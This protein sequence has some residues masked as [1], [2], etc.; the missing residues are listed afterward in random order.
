MQ[1]F[2]IQKV[3]KLAQDRPIII[4]GLILFL[5]IVFYLGLFLRPKIKEIFHLL[6]EVSRLKTAI[7][8][9]E[10]EWASIDSLKKQVLQLNEKIDYYEKR[11]PSEKEIPAVLK[12]LSEAA[13]KMNVKIIEIRPIE[14][15]KNKSV[16]TSLYYKV[17]IFLKAECG[18]HQLGRFLSR[19][20]MADRFMKISDIEIA[21]NPRKTN[22]HNVQL[23]VVTYG[24]QRS[25]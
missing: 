9:T 15:K 2:T 7:V 16:P 12:Y 22:T 23:T 3:K 5:I 21:A 4:N 18:Y 10:K 25:R 19:L 6:P 13:K 8:N 1:Q 17:P 20:E 24:M 11:L 14:Q